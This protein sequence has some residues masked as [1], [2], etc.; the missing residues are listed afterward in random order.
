MENEDILDEEYQYNEWMYNE[1]KKNLLKTFTEE[2]I[3]QMEYTDLCENELHNGTQ[4]RV[5]LGE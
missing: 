1:F 5:T 4:L 2:E 3:S